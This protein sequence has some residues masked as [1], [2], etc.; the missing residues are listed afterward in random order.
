MSF[1]ERN[2]IQTEEILSHSERHADAATLRGIYPN[3]DPVW[4]KQ[5][6]LFESDLFASNADWSDLFNLLGRVA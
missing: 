3:L 2:L 5:I 1:E 4:E 6:D